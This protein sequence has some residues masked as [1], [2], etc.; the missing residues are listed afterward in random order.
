MA[1]NKTV[2]QIDLAD[3]YRTFH[4][5][6]EECTFFSSGHGTFSREDHVLDHK[7]IHS[8]FKKVEIMSSIFPN[9]NDMELDIHHKKK[10]LNYMQ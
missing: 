8:K 3:I 5:K 1:L 4:F 7:T 9:H 6:T 2:V 10:L